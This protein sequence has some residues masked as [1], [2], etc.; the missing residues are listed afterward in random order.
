MRPT[1]A[2]LAVVTSA[3]LLGS[4]AG[5]D[6][7]TTEDTAATILI[8]ADLELTGSGASVGTAYKNALELKRDQLNAVPGGPRI[9]LD[10]KD[11]RSDSKLSAQ[12]ITQFAN[13]SNVAALITGACAECVID[14]LE[15]ITARKL[16]TVS[17]SPS[18]DV[19]LPVTE[20]QFIFKLAS[21]PDHNASALV[22]EIASSDIDRF[23][24]VTTTDPYGENM[25]EMITNEARN[26]DMTKVGDRPI[27]PG[28]AEVDTSVAQLV[29][30]APDALVVGALPERAQEVAVS[31]RKAGFDGPIYFDAAAAGDLFLSG[32]AQ[33]ASNGATMVFSQTLTID[34]VIAN[35]PAK[36]SR[37]AWFSDYTSRY[38]TYYGPSSFAADAVQVIV[39][40]VQRAGG[41]NG[42][43]LRLAIETSQMDGITGP[44]RLTPTNHSGLMP[45]AL[46]VLVA[47]SGRWHLKA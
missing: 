38:G 17:L 34:E 12:N 19:V 23:A 4:A 9:E 41:T 11:N 31:A 46:V 6:S 44:I 30:L 10:I 14:S 20:R 22:S 33:K 45:Q 36:A 7:A 18:S 40:G 35:T 37:A 25:R 28:D 27:A 3:A 29:A 16:P 32:E 24:L 43:A 5:C 2:M 42:D 39:N 47:D 15:T 1:R 13:N 8:A 26:A 21:N